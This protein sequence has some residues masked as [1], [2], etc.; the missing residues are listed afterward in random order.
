MGTKAFFSRLPRTGGRRG[1]KV[2]SGTQQVIAYGMP[3]LGWRD[4]YHHAL[5][6]NWSTFFGILAGL[7]LT[8]N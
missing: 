3:S 4:I 2:W 5:E 8:L 7:F 1:R 6:V